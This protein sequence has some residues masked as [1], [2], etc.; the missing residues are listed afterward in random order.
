MI[1]QDTTAGE[2]LLKLLCPSC[3]E[4]MSEYIRTLDPEGLAGASMKVQ[5][6]LAHYFLNN[7]CIKC[8]SAAVS[9][10]KGQ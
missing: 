3:K 9:L 7:S 2:D 10:A 6:K 5:L 8:K 1:E 4:K